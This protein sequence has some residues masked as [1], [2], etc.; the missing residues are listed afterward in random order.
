MRPGVLRMTP[1]Q[2]DRVLSGLVRHPLGRKTEIPQV[3]L[4]DHVDNYFDSQD[5]VHNEFVP[6]GKK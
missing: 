3:P 6:E 4:Q 2:S 5:V 1:K